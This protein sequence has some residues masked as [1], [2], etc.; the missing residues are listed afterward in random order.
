M[1]KTQGI[2]LIA[3]DMDGTLLNDKKQ[4]PPDLGEIVAELNRRGV[5]FTTASGRS[6]AS[7]IQSFTKLLGKETAEKMDYICDNGA[8][9]VEGGKVVTIHEMDWGFLRELLKACEGVEDIMIL[10][11]GVN[12]TYH[13]PYTP[14]FEQK[15]HSYYVNNVEVQDLANIDDVIF[16]VAICDLRGPENNV[17]KKLA[18]LFG[19][20]MSLQISG[21]EWV[22]VMNPGINKGV[23]LKD[24]RD[25]LDIAF[26]ETM[27]FGDFFNDV[28]LLENAGCSFV[29][30]N[31]HP[32]MFR[33]GRYVAKSNNECGVTDAIRRY[34][35]DG[36]PFPEENPQFE[37]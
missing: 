23:A 29:M 4:F 35:L 36:E 6:Y 9:I 14:I 25:R 30:A 24:L 1:E 33:K 19:E 18:P 2:R 26:E 37:P 13:L 27:A 34:V 5:R 28:G 15:A 11:C 17:Y 12:G 16:K 7:Q 8:F 20:T 32:E 21:V 31:S 10:F 22:D 3:C